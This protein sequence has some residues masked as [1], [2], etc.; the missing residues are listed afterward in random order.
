MWTVMRTLQTMGMLERLDELRRRRAGG[1]CLR[2]EELAQEENLQ[3][4][5]RFRLGQ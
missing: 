4:I 3:N 5:L 2:D 1:E